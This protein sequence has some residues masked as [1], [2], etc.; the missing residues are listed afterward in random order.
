MRG[1][2]SLAGSESFN[3]DGD[4]VKTGLGFTIDNQLH[5]PPTQVAT[6]PNGSG[7]PYPRWQLHLASMLG[8]LSLGPD[9]PLVPTS[10]QPST[11]TA[12]LIDASESVTCTNNFSSGD[13]I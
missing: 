3:E 8:H 7:T 2:V 5:S 9:T 10:T 11:V 1:L 13:D 4:T 6:I 12:S